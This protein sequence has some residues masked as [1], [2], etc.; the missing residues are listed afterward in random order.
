MT[1]DEIEQLASTPTPKPML[2]VWTLTAPDGRTWTGN[3]PLH[4]CGQEVHERVPANVR[5]AR[6]LREA[7]VDDDGE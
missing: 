3:S 7:M 4:C 1:P 6:I 5:L 2:G